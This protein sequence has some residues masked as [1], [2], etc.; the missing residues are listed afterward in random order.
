VVG[1]LWFITFS[2]TGPQSWPQSSTTVPLFVAF[3]RQHR[4]VRRRSGQ[5]MVYS[6]PL[7]ITINFIEEGVALFLEAQLYERFC[8]GFVYVASYQR[9][10]HF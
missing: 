1:G 3:V 7:S 9:V 4:P 10:Q 2:E 6:E 8:I 5:A